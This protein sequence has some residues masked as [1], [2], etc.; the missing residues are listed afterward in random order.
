MNDKKRKIERE[1]TK[2]DVDH[3]T[4]AK[5]LNVQHLSS[6]AQYLPLFTKKIRDPKAMK[7]QKVTKDLDYTKKTEVVQKTATLPQQMNPAK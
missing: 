1:A 4:Q 5:A 6:M 3:E 2:Y 7:K